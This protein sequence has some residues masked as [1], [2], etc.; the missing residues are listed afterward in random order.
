MSAKQIFNLCS[1]S[2]KRATRVHQGSLVWVKLKPVGVKALLEEHKDNLLF[3]SEQIQN[4]G[5]KFQPISKQSFIREKKYVVID[6]C[7]VPS[8]LFAQ[9]RCRY[10]VGG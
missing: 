4:I 10:S 9:K 5:W 2:F 6:F 1:Y 7:N 3:G 8:M